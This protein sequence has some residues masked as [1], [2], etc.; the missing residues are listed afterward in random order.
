MVVIEG[1]NG[2]GKSSLLEALHYA[3]Y[4][5]S[6]RT[7]VGRELVNFDQ[8]HFFIQVDFEELGQ[9]ATN[10]IQ[11]GFS[12]N[13][14]LVKF[15]GKPIHSYKDIIDHYR[16]IS[17]AEEDVQLVKGSPDERR[18]F[19]NQ[20]LMLESSDFIAGMRRYRQILGNRNNL[21]MQ[22]GYLSSSTK[23]QLSVWSKQLWEQ[24]RLIANARIAYLKTLEG[25]INGLVGKYF[26]TE[27]LALTVHF[28]YQQK[29][30]PADESFDE[31]WQ[32]HE[33]SLLSDEVRFRRSLFGAHLDDFQIEFRRRK[34]KVYASRGQQKLV[35]F[36]TKVAQVKILQEHG[37]PVA[38]LLDDFLTDFDREVLSRCLAVLADCTCQIFVTCPLKS[39]ILPEN[40]RG[41]DVTTICL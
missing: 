13:T 26:S 10:Q 25:H 34:A 9:A 39:F 22:A 12:K 24:A 41:V 4:L 15:N 14:K 38:L 3:C 29:N 35:V 23:E 30:L 1:D 8:D 20:A 18:T 2:S 7:H 33:Q 5:R 17:A 31:F 11:I 27:D 32:R 37:K 21:L 36:L 6:F 40:K 28:T 19:L 16:I